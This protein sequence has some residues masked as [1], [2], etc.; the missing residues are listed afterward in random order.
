M[1]LSRATGFLLANI[2]NLAELLSTPAGRTSAHAAEPARAS[3]LAD[4]GEV[5]YPDKLGVVVQ[6]EVGRP[7]SEP[8]TVRR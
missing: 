2:L 6:L 7:Y 4:P 8:N 3:P 5:E 1:Y